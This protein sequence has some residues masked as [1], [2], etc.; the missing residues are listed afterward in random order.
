M[1]LWQMFGDKM[2]NHRR[3]LAEVESPYSIFGGAVGPVRRVL[4][5][6]LGPGRRTERSLPAPEVLH[7]LGE[8]HYVSFRPGS[9]HFTGGRGGEENATRGLERSSGFRST[10]QPDLEFRALL[11]EDGARSQFLHEDPDWPG[12]VLA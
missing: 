12:K 7:E 10:K 6:V 11:T 4:A 2:G 3:S 1:A 5:H 8:T 9:R